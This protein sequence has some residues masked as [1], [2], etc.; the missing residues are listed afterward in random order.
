MAPQ[1][2]QRGFTLMELTIALVLS[3]IVLAL[4]GS[5]FV[6]SLS[7][8]RRGSDVRD[9]QVEAATIVDVMARD[10]RTASQAP[11]VTIHPQLNVEDGEPILSIAAAGPAIPPAVAAGDAVWILYLQR[12]DRH[13]VVREVVVPGDA[14]T[15]TVK[16]TRIVGTG[17]TKITVEQAGNGV[18]I[19]VEVARGRETAASRATAAPRNP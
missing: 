15:V 3:A 4:V 8:W 11:S 13:E 6:A 17:V 2:D 5:L 14:G 18:T 16:D 12:P 9:A 10:I 19:E 7:A 1:S